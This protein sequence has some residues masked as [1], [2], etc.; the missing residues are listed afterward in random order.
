MFREEQLF[1][2]LIR[3]LP[4]GL[5]IAVHNRLSPPEDGGYDGL[6]DIITPDGRAFPFVFQIRFRPR[7][8][9]LLLWRERQATHN[10]P[11]PALLICD[12]ITPALER[13]CIAQNIHFIDSAGNTSITVPGLF[14]RV[15]GRKNHAF[16]DEPGRMSFG[17][18]KLLF[19]LLSEPAAINANYRQLASIAGI[20]LGMVSKAFDYLE[21]QRFYRQSKQGRRLTDPDAL[22]VL[23]IREYALVLRPKLKTL[24]LEDN[25][26]WRSQHLEQGECWGGEAAASILS[27]GYLIPENIQLITPTPLLYR[28]DS[29]HLRP[30]PKGNFYL[31][32][33]FWGESFTLPDRAVV[34]LCIAELIA[35]QDDRNIETAGV[36]NDRYLQLKTA[37]LFGN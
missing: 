23:W 15:S 5:K 27:D 12:R 36:L 9:N 29:L 31:T 30:H 26:H 33:A 6:I 24:R 10:L 13:Y 3:N 20:S 11:Q 8:E 35:T 32:S 14:L 19:V 17:V 34:L 21:S 25:P 1:E 18:M 37:A 2:E 28:K 4:E 7:K 22:T 16:S